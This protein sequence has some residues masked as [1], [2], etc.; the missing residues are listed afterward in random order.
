MVSAGSIVP[1]TACSLEATMSHAI[2]VIDL[3][4]YVAG[5]P[6]ALR[7]TAREIHDALTHV[8]F[9][10]LI[11]HDVP[12][13]LIDQTFAEAARFHELPMAKKLALRLNEHN[14]GYMAKGRYA[15]WTSDVNKNDKPDLNEAFFVKRERAADNPLRLSGRRFTGPNMWPDE[16]DLPGFRARILDYLNAM[17]A[18]TNRL[19]PAI[20]VALDLD[21]AFFLP[22]FVD[23]Q[24]NL[25]LSHYPPETAEAN[26]F[27]IAP[28][29]DANFMTFLAQS[30]V[31]GLQV[32]TT[33]GDWVDVPFIPG[34]FAV[35]S[36]DTMRR[37]TNGRFLSTP[38]RAVPPVGRHR[39]AIP[40][41]LAPHIDTVIECL[42]TCIGPGETARW[43][44]ITY[45]QWITQWTDANYDPK[46][47]RD[48]AA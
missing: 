41:F 6:G 18:F 16:A 9:F 34:S 31:P 13:S 7:K 33:S 36:G 45:E 11:G 1:E 38:H 28:H 26:Q 5:S 29:T 47:Q 32:R 21:P 12:V 3:T 10:M 30:D 2:P 43:E 17:E 24:F 46:R 19:L 44:P 15:V 48:V 8:G 23:S 40:F 27:G 39:Y 4:N 25:R 20:A 14:N 35:N 22:H 42:L 37:W